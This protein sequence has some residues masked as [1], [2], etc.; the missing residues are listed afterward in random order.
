MFSASV[1]SLVYCLIY[2]LSQVHVKCIGLLSNWLRV[3]TFDD[4]SS[5]VTIM[6]SVPSGNKPSQAKNID[7]DLCRHITSLGDNGMILENH[8]ANS[9]LSG[10]VFDN[11]RFLAKSL[12]TSIPRNIS[13]HLCYIY[14]QCMHTIDQ[15]TPMTETTPYTDFKLKYAGYFDTPPAMPLNSSPPSSTYMPRWTGSALVQIMACR[16]F[17]AKPLSKPMLGYCQLEP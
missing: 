2:L 15:D 6:V 12:L 10:T 16:L 14:S 17:G 4:K 13:D 3:H 11:V 8:L 5:L 7:P 1:K 9:L